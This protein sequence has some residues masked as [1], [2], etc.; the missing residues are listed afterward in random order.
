MPFHLSVKVEKDYLIMKST[1]IINNFDEQKAI[2]KELVKLI[3][4]NEVKKVI[5]DVTELQYSPPLFNIS[6]IASLI[7]FYVDNLPIQLK[8]Y[9]VV[10]VL[11]EAAKDVGPKARFWETYARNRGYNFRVFYSME[12]AVKSMQTE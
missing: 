5:S 3:I 8:S 9:I 2:D 10:A 11:P 4:K 1:G 12:D 7:K 6:D